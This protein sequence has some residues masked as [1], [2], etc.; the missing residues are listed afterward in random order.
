MSI[1]KARKYR[2]KNV[3]WKIIF[4]GDKDESFE[5]KGYQEQCRMALL[6]SHM[7]AHLDI[8]LFTWHVSQFLTE[9][10]FLTFLCFSILGAAFDHQTQKGLRLGSGMLVEVKHETKPA[11]RRLNIYF[12]LT[13]LIGT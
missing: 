5:T 8:C 4:C 1:V 7:T 10:R 2:G 12:A 11:S 9:T 6:G 13:F 3:L